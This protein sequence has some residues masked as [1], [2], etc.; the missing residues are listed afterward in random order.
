M[1]GEPDIVSDIKISRIKWAG[2]VQ[3][4]PEASTLKKILTGRPGGRKRRRMGRTRKRWVNDLDD[5]LL[6][7]GVRRWRLRAENRDD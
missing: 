1:Y 5:D 6:K 2:H 3:R 4:M 7:L